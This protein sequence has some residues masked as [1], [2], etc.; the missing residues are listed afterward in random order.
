[1]NKTE[2]IAAVAAK[3]GRTKKDAEQAVNAALDTITAEIAKGEKVALAGFGTFETK[4][5]EARTGRNPL[6]GA[7]VEIAASNTPAFK[8]G[9]AMKDAVNQ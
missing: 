4:H 1:M 5:R 2:L 7:A 6:T 3:T 8:P 9:K